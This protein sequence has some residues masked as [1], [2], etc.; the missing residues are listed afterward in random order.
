MNAVV[1]VAIT[2]AAFFAVLIVAAIA[3]GLAKLICSF[4][5]SSSYVKHE[6]SGSER[7]AKAEQG[8]TTSEV[9]LSEADATPEASTKKHLAVIHEGLTHK[10]SV[11]VMVSSP[12]K[13]PGDPWKSTPG[14]TQE[15]NDGA[16]VPRESVMSMRMDDDGG[17]Y[18]KKDF[19]EHYG[20]ADKW[21][22]KRKRPR[23]TA[24][25][26]GDGGAFYFSFYSMTE[27]LFN[28]MILLN[29]YFLS[30]SRDDTIATVSSRRSGNRRR[31]RRGQAAP[32]VD[33]RDGADV[34]RRDES[35]VADGD[36]CH[37][38]DG[39]HLDLKR[40]DPSNSWWRVVL[41]R[42][43]LREEFLSLSP[44]SCLLRFAFSL[45]LTRLP[46][47]STPLLRRPSS[48]TLLTGNG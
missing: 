16:T 8:S 26:G 30:R 35:S 20:N 47:L 18:S 15:A 46:L 10:P 33:L 42:H 23:S 21:K 7:D 5:T 22:A 19:I 32:V 24:L 45:C 6:T 3:F 38:L 13:P 40:S 17:V 28:L 2:F 41:A 4:K 12:M 1:A 29:D 43:S 34:P 36:D 31:W 9:R 11:P 39:H 48:S 14:L 44:S 27:Y 25:D 37:G